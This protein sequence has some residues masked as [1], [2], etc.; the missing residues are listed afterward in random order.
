MARIE[1]VPKFLVTVDAEGD[2]L[3]SKPKTVTVRNAQF[4][5]RFQALCERYGFYPTYLTNYEMG[6][7]PLFREFGRDVLKRSV[8]EI[9][10]HVHAWNN[11]PEYNL[12]GDDTLNQPYLY[13]YPEDVMFAKIKFMTDLL[14][15]CFGA[16]MVS[17][18]AG[19]WAFDERYA[20]ML[21]EQGYLVDCSVTPHI[22]WER[23]SGDPR[24]HGGSDYSNFPDI[25]YFVDIN[26]LSIPGDSPLLELPTT[27]LL[28]NNPL[29]RFLLRHVSNISFA[30]SV[31][32]KALGTV[33]WLRP[34]PG[35]RDVML[36]I[37]KRAL[38]EGRSYVELMLHSSELMPAGSPSFR[39]ERAI[40]EL[41]QDLEAL[42]R[43]AQKT[44]VGSTLQQ[45]RQ[46]LM[47]VA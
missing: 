28:N 1:S 34:R 45:Y 8:G 32:S 40:E 10:L 24:Q 6:I 13:E 18:R 19:R 7:D 44:F 46:N 36:Q 4:L 26:D 16:K 38:C 23:T 29:A 15:D 21:I 2:D 33:N 11:P 9:G 3:W 43:E 47:A 39:T 27:I 30:G 31:V 42:F 12:T 22:S 35:N 20:R 37:L 14:E 25:A 5:P 17:H 41:Y